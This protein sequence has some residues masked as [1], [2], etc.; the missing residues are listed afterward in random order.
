MAE[1]SSADA[2]AEAQ[3]DIVFDGLDDYARLCLAE[4][5]TAFTTYEDLGDDVC[6]CLE[7]RA[8][9]WLTANYDEQGKR[10]KS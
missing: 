6:K 9:A 1:F 2:A 5:G 3:S 10:I 7:R 8:R 4:H